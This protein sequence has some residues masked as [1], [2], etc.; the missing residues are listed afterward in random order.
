MPSKS[1]PLDVLGGIIRQLDA[2]ND[3]DTLKAWTLVARPHVSRAQRLLF[4][5]ADLPKKA[6]WTAFASLLA[7]S[8]HL[9]SYVVEAY[10]S[11]ALKTLG[12]RMYCKTVV[13]QY[14]SDF[15]VSLLSGVDS[16]PLRTISYEIQGTP[17]NIL[18]AA[19]S[20]TWGRIDSALSHPRYAQLKT[21]KVTCKAYNVK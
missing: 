18:E 19:N 8:P 10:I 3:R 11:C 21:L 20:P 2:K 4:A 13:E 16:A 12:V 7:E 17:E 9:A 1:L 15:V 5:K 6:L 14:S